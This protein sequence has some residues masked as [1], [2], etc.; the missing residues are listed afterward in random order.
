MARKQGKK[1][2]LIVRSPEKL[3]PTVNEPPSR[4]LWTDFDLLFDQFRSNFEDLFYHPRS[5]MI[6]PTVRAR[7]PPLDV[8]DL[9]DK[10]ELMVE[11]PGVPKENIDIK[12][13]PNEVEISAENKT[14]A[15]RKGKTWLRRERSS[16]SFYR[17]FM[18]PEELRTD[19]ADAELKDGVLT[20]TLPKIAPKPHHK[21]QKINIR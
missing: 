13:T 10:Y 19:G 15:E 2:K 17:N 1:E 21:P 4:E 16:M 7:V 18:L 6:I 12:V 8:V 11:M 5:N 14:E 9:G 3:K 20:L